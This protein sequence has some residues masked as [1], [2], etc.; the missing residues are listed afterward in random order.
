M[1][2]QY[3]TS[4]VTRGIFS[5]AGKW[6]KEYGIVFFLSFLLVTVLFLATRFFIET[7]KLPADIAI[8]LSPHFDDATLSLGGFMAGRKNPVI[9]ATFFA[10]KPSEPISGNWD[11]ISGFKNSDEALV[12]RAKENIRALKQTNAYPLNLN[13]PDFQYR[14]DRTSTTTE[15][16]FQS[17]KRDISIILG[18]FS[19]SEK[20]SVYGPAEFGNEITHPDHKLLHDAFTSVAQEKVNQK[21]LHFF[22]YEDFPYIA[23]YETST[24]TP[25]KTFLEKENRRFTLHEILLPISPTTLAK[26]IESIK[27]YGS[28]NKAFDSLGENIAEKART[29]TE[30]RCQKNSFSRSVCEVVYEIL[31][32]N[33]KI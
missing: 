28:Q 21:N 15:K 1:T 5:R 18:K 19:D 13:Y 26:K 8:I 9:V 16:L 12:A 11:T 25:L 27:A 24:T 23:R 31:P 32:I 20:V 3:K 33:S 4:P 30:T 7:N 6:I 29:F 10:G 14:Y 17:V 22:F 2:K